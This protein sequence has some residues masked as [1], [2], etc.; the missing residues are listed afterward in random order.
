MV[1][2]KQGGIAHAAGL[3]MIAMILSRI[4]GYVRDVVI[5]THF[6]QDF[7]TDAYN[8]A[9]SIPDF[10]YYLLVGGALSSAFIPVFS[11]YVATG[12]EEEGWQVASTIINLV[13][14]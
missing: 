2:Q 3:I 12:K 13:I 9:F 10:L 5:Y 1:K 4:F 11:S 7:R 8:A 6:G 14:I